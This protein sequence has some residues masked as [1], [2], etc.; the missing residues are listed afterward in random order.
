[1][2][3]NNNVD[4]L[5]GGNSV[6]NILRTTTTLPS[7][8]GQK[9]IVDK[10]VT[11]P[12]KILSRKWREKDLSLHRQK[13]AEMKPITQNHPS[14]QVQINKQ[15]NEQ[16]VEERFTEIERENRI[17]FEKITQI[18]LKSGSSGSGT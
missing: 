17:L 1:L 6:Q 3:G 15:K 8:I 11:G 12:S 5:Q 7:T 16:M 18:H 2:I 9:H 13:L 4:S 10:S 14:Q